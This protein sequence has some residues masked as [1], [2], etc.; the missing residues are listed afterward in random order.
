M[1]G[2]HE[3]SG[4]VDQLLN[5]IDG[6]A[7]GQLTTCLNEKF[8][9]GESKETHLWTLTMICVQKS[10]GWSV[11]V[12]VVD[13]LQLLEYSMFRGKSTRVGLL[14]Y[15]GSLPLPHIYS[16]DSQNRSFK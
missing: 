16:V 9:R 5:L 8:G 3:A 14:P 6:K 7:K 1:G 4:P 11:Y 10:V 2:N 12:T 15:Y 13:A